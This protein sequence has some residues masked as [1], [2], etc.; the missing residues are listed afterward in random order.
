MVS[1]EKKKKKNRKWKKNPVSGN[2]N[3]PFIHFYPP[4]LP[5]GWS[6]RHFMNKVHKGLFFTTS[7][8]VILPSKKFKFRAWV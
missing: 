4:G 8:E 5:L 7:N 2:G 1:Y 3:N 6:Q